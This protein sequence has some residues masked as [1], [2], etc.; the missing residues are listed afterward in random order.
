[1]AG[2][3]VTR[4]SSREAYDPIMER[5]RMVANE[6][7]ERAVNIS[8]VLAPDEPTDQEELPSREQWM[9]LET[10]AVNLSPNAWDDPDAVMDLY[11]LRRAFDP[12]RDHEP[13]K[14][15]SMAQRRLRKMLPDPKVS[16]ANPE[17][18]THQRRLKE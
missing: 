9:L 8:E 12:A 14:Q 5:A 10:V 18:A 7:W 15:M 13:L 6:L 16:P 11:Q 17:F 4:R 1:M 3:Q 2:K